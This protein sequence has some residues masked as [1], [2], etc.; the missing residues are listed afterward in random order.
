[1]RLNKEFGATN[2]SMYNIYN[3]CYKA[4]NTTGL[5]YVNTGCEDDAGL[6]N[7]MNDPSVKKN[8]NFMVDKEWTA[9]N[10]TVFDEY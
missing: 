7:F 6:T 10:T 2:T 4:K 3:K 8:W 5:K 1:M 9:C